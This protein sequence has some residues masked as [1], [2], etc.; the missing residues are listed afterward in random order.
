MKPT[1]LVLAA[2][3][4][5]RYGSLKQ[6]DTLGP[7]G[8]TII[9][10][11]VYDA[12]SAGFG[13]VVFVIRRSFEDD[14]RKIVS[15]KFE[16]FV[17]TVCAYQE[18]DACVGDFA[19]PPDRE[20]PWGTAHAILASQD[21]IDEPFA[22]VNADDYYGPD[23]FRT[24]AA[25]L[26]EHAAGDECA[27]VGYTLANTLSE[28]GAVSRGVAQCD[29][30]MFLTTIVERKHI[31]KTAEGARYRDAGGVPHTLTGNEIVS[32]NLWGFHPSVFTHFQS[33]FTRFLAESGHRKDSELYIPSVVDELVASGKVAVRVLRTDESWFGITY[34]ADRSIAVDC[35]RRLIDEGV[36]PERLWGP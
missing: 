7:N 21:V 5:T 35:I 33:Q 26:K 6:I 29:D 23:S 20:K 4:G 28:H 32:M 15:S 2:G 36:Y 3:L 1:L 31:E 11:S 10:Y 18:L 34:R 19:V 13:K 12:I 14:F 9:D 25:F 22:V 8:E 24:M 17:P 27:M 30:R 16:R